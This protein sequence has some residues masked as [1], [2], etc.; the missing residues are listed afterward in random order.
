MPRVGPVPSLYEQALTRDACEHAVQPLLLA[1]QAPPRWSCGLGAVPRLRRH[2]RRPL[3]HLGARSALALCDRTT[4]A[5]AL[6]G[7]PFELW[8]AAGP[9]QSHHTRCQQPH[10]PRSE[11]LMPDTG[12][13]EDPSTIGKQR[14]PHHADTE[15]VRQGQQARSMGCRVVAVHAHKH[16]RARPH[17]HA[18]IHTQSTWA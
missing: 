2:A 6:R 7:R 5:P 15:L 8:L 10:L 9:D 11:G 14:L 12:H 4:R 3:Q 13:A 17:A 1:R 18:H 16:A